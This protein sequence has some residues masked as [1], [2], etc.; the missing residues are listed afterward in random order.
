MKIAAYLDRGQPGVGIVSSDLQTSCRSSCRPRQ[1]SCGALPLVEAAGRG[2]R[3]AGH[4][5][6]DGAR[7]GPAHGADPASAPQHLLRRQ[8]LPRACE[9]VR[10]QRLRQQRQVGRR[11]PAAPDHLHQGARV[12]G[13]AGRRHRS[14]RRRCPPRSTTRPNW[15]SSS[16]RAARASASADAHGPRLGLHDRQRRHRA[17]LAE[18][19]PAVAAR[20]V[21][22]T[23]SARWAR[24]W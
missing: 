23:P 20:Q 1:R 15:P 16:A 21:A 10:R 3:A 18:P 13:R 2:E 19:P 6:A 4:R 9:G 12:G 14:S 5:R 8:E 17:R 7:R 22:S 11:H 24:G